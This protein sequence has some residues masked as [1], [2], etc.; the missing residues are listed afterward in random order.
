M[1]QLKGPGVRHPSR[2]FQGSYR[3][4]WFKY[5]G[6]WTNCRVSPRPCGPPAVGRHRA[7]QLRLPGVEPLDRL[8]QPVAH[9][10]FGDEVA[11]RALFVGDEHAHHPA[12]PVGVFA[13]E[14][15]VRGQRGVHL[16]HF[17]FDGRDHFGFRPVAIKRPSLLPLA[18]PV[19]RLGQLDLRQRTG[20]RRGKFVH[21]HPHQ[22]LAFRQQPGMAGVVAQVVR[23]QESFDVDR[24][25]L[26]R[27]GARSLSHHQLFSL[28]SAQDV[29]EHDEG[30][31]CRQYQDD[32]HGAPPWRPV[33][34]WFGADRHP[35]KRTYPSRPR[36]KGELDLLCF[37]EEARGRF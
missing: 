8:A 9:Q 34:R 23:D 24:L 4:G 3:H 22:V 18:H 37:A 14:L 25:G 17:A 1:G 26:G 32:C 31:E 11:S 28:P 10:A 2:R 16:D 29:V 12:A 7:R 30:E 27:D 20:E 36:L 33:P 15:G 6:D 13:Q 5:G 35:A 19:A 21:A